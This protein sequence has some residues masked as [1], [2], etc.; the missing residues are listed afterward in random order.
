MISL[1]FQFCARKYNKTQNTEVTATRKDKRGLYRKWA[2]T[3]LRPLSLSSN[4][5]WRASLLNHRRSRTHATGVYGYH[6]NTRPIYGPSKRVG[7]YTCGTTYHGMGTWIH[8]NW[9][10]LRNQGTYKPRTCFS[11]DRFGSTV[12]IFG[13]PTTHIH[14]PWYKCRKL[15][16]ARRQI[17]YIT[18]RLLRDGVHYSLS[19]TD[20]TLTSQYI[21]TSPIT[22]PTIQPVHPLTPSLFNSL[23]SLAVTTEESIK[24]NAFWRHKRNS[25]QV[26][27][28]VTAAIFLQRS[29][30]IP[31]LLLRSISVYRQRTW[32]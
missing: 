13:N 5:G 16:L 31:T 27:V 30:R 23:A 28:H 9:E 6:A 3:E 17:V 26:K 18:S 15:S 10:W 14:S 12:R 2:D 21:L 19:R 8:R 20:H 7:Q 25:S 32:A 24:S 11:I 29:E 4:W 22:C 1:L